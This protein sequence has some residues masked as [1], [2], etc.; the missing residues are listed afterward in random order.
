M[1]L[2]PDSAGHLKGVPRVNLAKL[3]RF[4]VLLTE[5]A[6]ACLSHCGRARSRRPRQRFRRRRRVSTLVWNRE[7][8]LK[9]WI[10]SQLGKHN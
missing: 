3:L 6:G 4:T 2:Q 7:I 1:N 10:L 5:N 8:I 9:D